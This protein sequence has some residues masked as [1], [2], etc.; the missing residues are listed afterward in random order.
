MMMKLPD[1][2]PVDLLS[3]LKKDGYSEHHQSEK[4]LYLKHPAKKGFLTIPMDRGTLRL[5]T[6]Q[7]IM[8]VDLLQQA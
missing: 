3:I 7:S 5:K 2:T 1:I 6:F 4:H 8:V